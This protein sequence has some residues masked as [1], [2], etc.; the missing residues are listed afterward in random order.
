MTA[1]PVIIAYAGINGVP[2]GTGG[3]NGGGGNTPDPDPV[4]PLTVTLTSPEDQ[5]TV[6]VS[7]PTFIV[8]VDTSLE[9]PSATYTLHLQYAAST[10]FSAATE[11]TADFTAIDAGAFLAAS[12]VPATTYWRARV[13]QGDTWRSAWSDP[14]TFTVSASADP[15]QIPVTWTVLSPGGARH[16][17]LWHIV[18]PAGAP[19]DKVTVYGEGFSGSGNVLL[20]GT[21]V[22]VDS[23]T[24]VPQQG[25]PDDTRHITGT[26]ITPE[27]YAVVITVPG[28]SPPGGALEVTD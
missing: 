26:D 21:P 10:D 9:D 23:W 17:H 25:N 2:T 16:I 8:G 14:Q 18:P 11:L 6:A 19:G 13:A 12:S 24:F 20:G 5:S 3:D 27:H 7:N 15:S 28:A 22:V 1:V 4:D